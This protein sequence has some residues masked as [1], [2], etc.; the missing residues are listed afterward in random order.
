M[1][2]RKPLLDPSHPMFNRPWVRWVTAGFPTA[3]SLVEFSTGATWWG[4]AFLA[5]GAYAFKV[6]IWDR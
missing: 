6:L 2:D 3:W 4:V 5:A 1:A